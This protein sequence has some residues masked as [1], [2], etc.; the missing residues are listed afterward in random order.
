VDDHANSNGAV[1]AAAPTESRRPR[2]PRPGGLT[3]S[4][5]EAAWALGVSLR[6]LDA[7]KHRMPRPLPL[8]RRPR[9]SREA[10]RVWIEN[11]CKCAR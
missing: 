4:R 6:Q 5:E 9:W 1:E 11:G 8:S 3:Y 2:R 10:I 7:L